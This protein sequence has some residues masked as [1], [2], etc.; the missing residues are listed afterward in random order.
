[1]TAK[2]R[3]NIARPPSVPHAK[4]FFPLPPPKN[5]PQTTADAPSETYA[6]TLSAPEG[7]SAILNKNAPITVKTAAVTVPA[8]V[9]FTKGLS[10]FIA[11]L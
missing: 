8:I 1:M 4:P 9:P 2:Q 7:A 10:F 11:A 5:I 6:I 3:A